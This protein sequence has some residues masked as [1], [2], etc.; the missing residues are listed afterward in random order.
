MK[1]TEIDDFFDS[2]QKGAKYELDESR[3]GD[4]TLNDFKAWFPDDYEN[5][6][7]YLANSPFENIMAIMKNRKE[8]SNDVIL[9]NTSR[10]QVVEFLGEIYKDRISKSDDC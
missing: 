6:L 3:S 5:V 2:L 8:N 7:R 1:K 4:T 10:N 9:I